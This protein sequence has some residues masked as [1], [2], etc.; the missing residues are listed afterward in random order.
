MCCVRVSCALACVDW[1]ATHTGS[2]YAGFLDKETGSIEVGKAAD[3]IVLD[4]N[5]F[6][7]PTHDIH[8][9]KVTHTFVD[10]ALVYAASASS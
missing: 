7:I 2:A 10:G 9:A 3:I 5:L 6:E 1:G 8:T 4:K